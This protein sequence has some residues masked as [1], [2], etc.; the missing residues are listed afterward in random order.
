MEEE[1]KLYP[2]AVVP[3]SDTPEESF[4]LADLGYPDSMVRN[5][6][7]STNTLSEVMDTYMDRVV[8]E[9]VFA[10]FGRQ[11]PVLVKMLKPSERTPLTVHPDDEIASQRFDFLGKAKLWHIVK[12]APGAKIY[13]GF[14]RDVCS[15]EFYDAVKD[16]SVESLLNAVVP[17]VGQTYHIAPGT[18]HAAGPGVEIAEIAES[19]PL[20]FRIFNWGRPE[21]EVDPFDAELTLEAAFDFIDYRALAVEP[22]VPERKSGV[23]RLFT[24]PEFTV[25]AIQLKDTLR[26]DNAGGD[27]FSAY[28]CVRGEAAFTDGS[29]SQ[30]GK[31]GVSAGE[32]VLVPA[33]L[34]EYYIAPLAGDTLLL[35]VTVEREVPV[36]S[37]SV[38]EEPLYN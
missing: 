36:E 8:G 18:V 24:G 15:Q 26:I 14:N 10:S 22:L 16:G 35:E 13:L 7:L 37:V 29:P 1:K 32:A 30:E 5:G 28:L 34:D 33:E 25:S 9:G 31:A 3:V 6:W 17:S 11:F 19:S 2:F 20:D 23:D 27:F 4:A 12:A 38:E 21:G